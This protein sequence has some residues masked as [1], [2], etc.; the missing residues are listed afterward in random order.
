VIAVNRPAAENSPLR[1]NGEALD[2]LLEGTSYSL[3]RKHKGMTT[4]SSLRSGGL[5]SS[6]F[7]SFC[8]LRQSSVCNPS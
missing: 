6:R 1:V 8:L 7:S 3:F 4:I 5:S 2:T